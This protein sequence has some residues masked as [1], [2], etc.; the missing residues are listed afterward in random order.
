VAPGETE[1]IEFTRLHL[2]RYKC[3]TSVRFVAALP[4]T[5]SGKI[6]KAELRR[7]NQTER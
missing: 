5:A 2:A 1:V 6:T 7:L 4:K 3:P